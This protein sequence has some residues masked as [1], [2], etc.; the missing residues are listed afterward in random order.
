MAAAIPPKP[1]WWPKTLLDESSTAELLGLT[2]PTLR[3]WRCRRT[4]ALPFLKLGA[5]VRYNP[6]DIWKWLC[7][8]TVRP[9]VSA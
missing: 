4:R 3:D 6:D 5:S 7:A 9:L 2:I 1:D 8:N